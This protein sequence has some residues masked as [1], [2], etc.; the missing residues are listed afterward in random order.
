[1]AR[2]APTILLTVEE[3]KAILSVIR[4]SSSEQRMVLRAKIV[5]LA[6]QG[7]RNDEIMNQLKVSKPVVIKWRG[8]FAKDRLK[9]LQDA[10]RPGKPRVYGPEV[11]IKV[12]AEAC[13]PPEGQTQWSTRDLAKHIGGISHV[14]VHRIL[15][16]ERIKPHLYK[17][18]KDSSDP[19]FTSK[20]IEVVGLYMD[21]PENAVVLSVDE[22]TAIQSLGRPKPNKPVR[23]GQV[24]RIN[25]EYIRYGTKSLIAALAVHEGTVKGECFDRHSHKEFLIF[26]KNLVRQYP[27]KELHLIVD[28]LSM[29]KHEKIR[30]WLHRH[31]RV[32][33]H[34][35]P[36]YASWLNQI[37][38]WF[39]I[40]ARKVIRR[41]VFTSKEDLVNKI[42]EFIKRYNREAK[43]FRW[44]YT[45]DPLTI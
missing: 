11:R 2:K 45:G 1:M 39:S 18:W 27:D 14:A 19:D 35:T 28:N 8:R 24:E 37:E 29:H 10:P 13:K 32:Q 33:F 3:K 42:M 9:G 20:M 16:A 6:S 31:S 12:A 40:L 22:K 36:T 23:P 7:F 38:L 30:R 34:F 26:L 41:G 25:H 5:L 44:T 15:S 4:K 21:P 43:P 17:M